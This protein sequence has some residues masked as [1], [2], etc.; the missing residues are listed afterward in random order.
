MTDGARIAGAL[1]ACLSMA[2]VAAPAV[3][4]DPVHLSLNYEGSL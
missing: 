1:L 2:A 3:A 4:Q